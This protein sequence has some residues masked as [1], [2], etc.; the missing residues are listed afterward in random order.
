VNEGDIGIERPQRRYSSPV[1][2]HFIRFISFAADPL[3]RRSSTSEDR[4]DLTGMNEMP[5][6]PAK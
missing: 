4:R 2:G 6:A 5:N 3:S 1:N